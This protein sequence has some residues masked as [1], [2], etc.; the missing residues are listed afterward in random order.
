MAGV[1]NDI[2][3]IPTRTQFESYSTGCEHR[4]HEIAITH[5]KSLGT[6]AACTQGRMKGCAHSG[7]PPAGK[8][9]GLGTLIDVAVAAELIHTASR[10]TTTSSMKQIPDVG[11]LPSTPYRGTIPLSWQ[12][13][14]FLPEPL[15]SCQISALMER[16]LS[17]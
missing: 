2:S 16:S 5:S 17:W 11:S 6:L 8:N 14:T 10:S 4:I 13:I 3:S 15:T 1:N 7:A 12:G 9:S